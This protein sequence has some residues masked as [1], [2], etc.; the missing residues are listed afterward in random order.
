M[1]QSKGKR[2]ARKPSPGPEIIRGLE[3]LVQSLERGERLEGRFTVRT[4]R[5]PAA[6]SVWTPEGIARLREQFR[7]SQAVFARL[8]GV[9]VKTLQSWEQGHSPPSMACRLLDCIRDDPRPWERMLHNASIT[10]VAG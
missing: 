2:P 5:M 7:A 1:K 8:L 9:S 10:K 6:P 3:G 4:V